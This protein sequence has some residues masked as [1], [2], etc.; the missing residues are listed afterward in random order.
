MRPG[1][2]GLEVKTACA[3]ACLSTGAT[4]GR[5]DGQTWSI[6]Q[7]WLVRSS[8]SRTGDYR[9]PLRSSSWS[10]PYLI[11]ANKSY[12]A[13]LCSTSPP[14]ALLFHCLLLLL[15]LLVHRHRLVVSQHSELMDDRAFAI[16]RRSS[17][18]AYL[19]IFYILYLFI[20]H[21]Y[22]AAIIGEKQEIRT[23]QKQN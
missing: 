20:I 18:V 12:P 16:R 4:D 8:A 9:A 22:T 6:N 19:L 11:T 13:T 17:A 5:T 15:T 10:K 1:G 21:R 3:C 14:P 23:N 2:T 7:I